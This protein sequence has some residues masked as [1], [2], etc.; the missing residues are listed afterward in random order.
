MVVPGPWLPRCLPGRCPMC[1]WFAGNHDRFSALEL[2][3]TLGVARLFRR[4]TTIGGRANQRGGILIASPCVAGPRR[5]GNLTFSFR[6]SFPDDLIWGRTKAGFSMERSIT[7]GISELAG[8]A[9]F[10]H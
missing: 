3:V 1:R 7:G 9:S 10:L 8:P 5:I 2:W 6:K 4:L